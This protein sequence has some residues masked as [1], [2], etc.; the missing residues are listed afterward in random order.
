M[1]CSVVAMATACWVVVREEEYLAAERVVAGPVLAC[2]SVEPSGLL[3]LR[4]EVSLVS[5]LQC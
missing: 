3:A 4:H 2:F 1:A 5:E